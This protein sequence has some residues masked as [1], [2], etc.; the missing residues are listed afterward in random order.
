MFRSCFLVGSAGNRHRQSQ[1]EKCSAD[2]SPVG[3]DCTLHAAGAFERGH[4]A[5]SIP[6]NAS[7]GV[8]LLVV[9]KVAVAVSR[10][11]KGRFLLKTQPR[12]NFRERDEAAVAEA[13]A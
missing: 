4:P 13:T 3:A 5:P 1:L 11:E 7:D 2:R 12:R 8:I 9:A 6:T 10:L